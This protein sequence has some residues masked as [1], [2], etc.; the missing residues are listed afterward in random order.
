MQRKKQKEWFTIEEETD[1]R[2]SGPNNFIDQQTKVALSARK[3]IKINC[4][5]CYVNILCKHFSL[6]KSTPS[7]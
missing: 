2:G 6:G 5:A 1:W 4:A 7:L 3:H